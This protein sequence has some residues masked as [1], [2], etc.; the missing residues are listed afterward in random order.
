MRGPR[1]RS[2]APQSRRCAT[3]PRC[4]AAGARRGRARSRA[5]GGTVVHLWVQR[6]AGRRAASTRCAARTGTGARARVRSAPTRQGGP[7]CGS[8]PRRRKGEY[9]RIRVVRTEHAGRDGR[10]CG[11]R[12]APAQ[13]R[14][15]LREREPACDGCLLAA[16][17]RARARGL[18]GAAATIERLL[19]PVTRRRRAD[20]GG[21][22][23]ASAA[24]STLK[25]AADPSG[26]L[27]FDKTTLTAKAGKVTID[28]D[29][30]SE[31]AARRRGRGQRRRRRRQDGRQRRTLAAHRR[32]QARHLQVLL[33]GRRPPAAG[34]KGTLTVN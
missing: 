15:E 20:R 11:G 19:E 1:T 34:M 3:P 24:A 12:P 13:T 14:S 7:T 9:D 6:P 25:I 18:R 23:P 17:R 27:K 31:R 5:V 4:A 32:P 10:P 2:R 30:P 33:P 16:S 8:R 22:T 21:P 29:N 26:A 28:F